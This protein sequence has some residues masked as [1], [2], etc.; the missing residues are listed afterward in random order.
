[1][2]LLAR[3]LA[4]LACAAAAAAAPRALGAQAGAVLTGQVLDSAGAPIAGAR[5]RIP[6]LE[7][8]AGADSTGRFRLES[9][10]AGR[11]VVIAEAPGYRGARE[12]ID[13][14]ASGEVARTFSLTPNSHVLAAVEVRARARRM[15][16]AK[17]HEFAQ[18]QGH[19]SGRFL[20]PA[21][22]ARFNG[23]P[24]TE[25]LKTILTGARF[26]RNSLGQMTIVSA[27]ALN[28]TTSL[29]QTNNM[30]GC[31][32]QIWQDGILMADPNASGDFAVATAP[33]SRQVTTVHA[34]SDRDF[35]VSN[36]L[37]DSYMAAE[38][39]SDNTTTPPGFR[40]GTPTC[41]V[42]VLWTRVPMED[43]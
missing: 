43:K 39:Y 29:R 20:D 24:L 26:D 23:Q 31:G 4:F 10:A 32:V 3:K 33:T 34:G 22:M 40:T 17:L 28:T 11:I 15:L 18:R 6:Q 16:P 25:A 30:K 13:V 8:I 2:Q 36:L 41:G 27:R 5:L 7:R 9:L 14:P 37:A 38:Y 21:Q 19:G 12:T 35:D 1:M 42:L